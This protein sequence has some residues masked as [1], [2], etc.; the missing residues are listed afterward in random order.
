MNWYNMGEAECA[1]RSR[2]DH[3]NRVNVACAVQLG[4]IVKLGKVIS[5]WVLL[6]PCA[7]CFFQLCSACQQCSAEYCLGVVIPETCGSVDF[8]LFFFRWVG[9]CRLY[10]YALVIINMLKLSATGPCVQCCR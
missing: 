8:V 9:Q 10:V 7:S 2:K 4:V 6:Q 5:T 1:S 3:E